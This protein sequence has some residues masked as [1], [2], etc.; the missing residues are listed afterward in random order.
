ME[1]KSVQFVLILDTHFDESIKPLIIAVSKDK[2][3]LEEYKQKHLADW[4]RK[5]S[6]YRRYLDIVNKLC[7]EMPFVLQ[8]PIAPLKGDLISKEDFKD[9]NKQ[10]NEYHIAE[11]DWYKENAK[12]YAN[13]SK[14]AI[15][16]AIEHLPE[17]DLDLGYPFNLDTPSPFLYEIIEVL[18]V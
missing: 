7:N 10:M 8:K 5:H 9:R 18:E 3:N 4:N 6:A 12:H 16:A 17:G 1:Q 15:N 2:E 11:R 13:I 14:L